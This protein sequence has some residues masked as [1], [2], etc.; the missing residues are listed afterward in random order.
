MSQVY[1]QPSPE[2]SDAFLEGKRSVR[3]P[4]AYNDVVTIKEG[5]RKGQYGW[6][7]GLV[8][9]EP[10]PRY[11]VELSSGQG[12]LYLRLSEIELQKE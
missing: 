12:D 10:E 7:V 11:T 5:E 2:D 3:L 9:S 6:I 4:L 1:K 8:E